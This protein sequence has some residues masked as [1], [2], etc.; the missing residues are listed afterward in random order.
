VTRAGRLLLLAA[1]LGVPDGIMLVMDE[2]PIEV[3][4]ERRDLYALSKSLLWQPR[5][6]GRILIAEFAPATR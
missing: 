6:N 2:M 3:L 5:H 4:V 1:V